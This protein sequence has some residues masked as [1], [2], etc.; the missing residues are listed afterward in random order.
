MACKG[1]SST[2]TGGNTRR[3]YKHALP[4]AFVGAHICARRALRLQKISNE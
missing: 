3:P 4:V 1:A 2:R